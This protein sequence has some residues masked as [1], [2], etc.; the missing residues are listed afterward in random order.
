[1]ADG[2]DLKPLTRREHAFQAR[3]PVLETIALAARAKAVDAVAAQ[4]SGRG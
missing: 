2:A 3:L 4:P 1:M